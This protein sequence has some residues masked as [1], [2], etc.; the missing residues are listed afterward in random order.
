[1]RIETEKFRVGLSV[2]FI[3]AQAQ[4]D[5]LVS[6][7]NEVQAVVNYLKALIN[8][9]RQEGSLLER[10]GINAPGRDPIEYSTKNK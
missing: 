4:R 6:R 3:V 10:R 1:M 2:N 9:Y 7:I 8:F 5:L